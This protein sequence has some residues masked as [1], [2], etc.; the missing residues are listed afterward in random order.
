MNPS[1]SSALYDHNVGVLY[2]LNIGATAAA[3]G[4][5][6]PVYSILV[7]SPD[8]DPH[9]KVAVEAYGRA[10]HKERPELAK[11]LAVRFL[12]ADE[13]I[14][15][16]TGAPNVATAVSPSAPWRQM[17]VSAARMIEQGLGE[18]SAHALVNKH[19][20]GETIRWNVLAKVDGMLALACLTN[21]RLLAMAA[22]L[23]KQGAPVPVNTPAQMAH[24]LYTSASVFAPSGEWEDRGLTSAIAAGLLT[25]LAE[26]AWG[27]SDIVIAKAGQVH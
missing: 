25:S 7:L 20:N 12:G 21:D 6:D 9:A 5:D 2:T 22:E 17:T 15:V 19:G 24:F 16:K 8:T 1:E 11:A 4:G 3:C 13:R 26:Q 18:A 27:A 23:K 10:I 14:V